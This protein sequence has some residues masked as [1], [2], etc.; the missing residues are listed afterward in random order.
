MRERE[1]TVSPPLDGLRFT[2]RPLIHISG[3]FPGKHK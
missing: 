2:Q 1:A 3:A